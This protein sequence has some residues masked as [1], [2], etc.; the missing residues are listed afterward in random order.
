MDLRAT[1]FRAF[2]KIAELGSFTRASEALN[3][4]QPALSASIREMERQ[5]G[6]DL[7]HRTSR[8][9]SLTRQ[10][11]AFVANARRLVLESDW[12]HQK[13]EELRTNALR[14]AVQPHS[15]FFPERTRLTDS[16]LKVYSNTSI[17]VLTLGHVRIFDALKEENVDL[18]LAIEPDCQESHRQGRDDELD[19]LIVRRRP[20]R[21]II[22]AGHPLDGAVKIDDDLL[23]GHSVATIN[24]LHGVSLADAVA[25]G[26]VAAGA[27]LVR[28]PEADAF[29]LLRYATLNRIMC[30]DLGWFDPELYLAGTGEAHRLTSVAAPFLGLA[31]QLSVLRRRGEQRS[32]AM[33]FWEHA[34]QS[35]VEEPVCL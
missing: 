11:Q 9:V 22:P 1:P 25:R 33:D 24:R 10:G 34:K 28:P 8:R 27:R 26:L 23:K 13:A 20:M 3:V 31:T 17:E 7:F 19:R 32:A 21:L 5:L 16:F 6:F 2:L 35:A 15:V 30:V 12:L 14:L 29:S 4:S 18:A